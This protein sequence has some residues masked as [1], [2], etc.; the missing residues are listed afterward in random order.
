MI[1]SRRSVETA[2][3]SPRVSWL[4]SLPCLCLLGFGLAAGGCATGNS[5]QEEHYIL[6]AARPGEPLPPV[7]S[8][9]LEVHRFSVN[10]AFST[11]N[12]VYRTGR[13]EYETDYY[14]QFLIP[15]GAMITE[16]T[17]DWLARSGLFSH[18]LP[19]GSRI[20]PDYTLEGNVTSL[21]GDFSD[22]SAPAA[23]M[24]LRLFVLDNAGG[25]KVVF[26]QTYRAATPVKDT[27]AGVFV[28]ALNTSL[29]DI[30]T[31]LETDLRK[32]LAEETQAG[33]ARE[34]REP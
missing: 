17:R 15:P 34:P 24:E 25:E 10:A 20:A 32:T 31:R 6:E 1:R 8:G 33:A 30:L 16:Q 5:Q 22:K 27:T 11:R 3:G 14:R 13:L 2:A 18:I 29:A 4:L 26:A 19:M 28:E 7:V 12:L 23:V 9:A 21:Y